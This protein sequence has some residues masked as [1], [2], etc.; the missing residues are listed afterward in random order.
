MKNILIALAG[1]LIIGCGNAQ[2]TKFIR[3]INSFKEEKPNNILNFGKIVQ[4][5]RRMT[6][7]EAVDF[8]YKGD[9]AKLYCKQK[10]VNMETEKVE[11]ISQELYL[12]S[13]CMKI[14]MGSYFLIAHSSYQCQNPNDMLKIRLTLSIVDKSFKVRDSMI[15]Y[16]G[17]DFESDITG[18]L[19]PKNGKIFIVSDLENLKG[20]EA[21]IL[22]VNTESFRF[23]S[24]KEYKNL[25]KVSDDLTKVL[26]MLE[27]EG[28]FT[29]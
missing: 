2:E 25:T 7:A 13:K 24:I 26:N 11:G 15:V 19:N 27:W 17:S 21:S 5:E 6:F 16:T 9:T 10:I 29:N 18:L 22:K 20:K 4:I 28:I 1:T 14:D 8:V 23:E 12:P 3:Y